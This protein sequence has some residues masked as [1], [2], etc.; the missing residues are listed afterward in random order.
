MTSE[1]GYNLL[2]INCFFLHRN[3]GGYLIISSDYCFVVEDDTAV[4][5]YAL[6]AVDSKKFEEKLKIA[7]I[8]ELRNKYPLPVDEKINSTQE[9]VEEESINEAQKLIRSFHNENFEFNK[10]PESINKTHPSIISISMLPHITDSSVSKRLLTCILAALK[11]NGNL[12]RIEPVH[13]IN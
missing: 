6:A 4:C 1:I 11:A 2:L 5:G 7:W 8:P 10:V 12:K 3:I 9:E 13:L